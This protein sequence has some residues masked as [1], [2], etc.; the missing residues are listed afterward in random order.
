MV[1]YFAA[2]QTYKEWW[3]TKLK[4]LRSLLQGSCKTKIFWKVSRDLWIPFALT[5]MWLAASPEIQIKCVTIIILC[6]AIWGTERRQNGLVPLKPKPDSGEKGERQRKIGP[7][8]IVKTK[9]TK[10]S[11]KDIGILSV[12]SNTSLLV[13]HMSFSQ[14]QWVGP[15][16]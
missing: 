5:G 10:M 12:D 14:P 2:A 13:K 7:Y 9:E 6:I 11:P 8:Y 1:I 3:K 15:S 4:R 16:D